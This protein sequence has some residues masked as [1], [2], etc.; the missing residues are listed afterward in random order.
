MFAHKNMS[1]KLNLPII[2]KL[3]YRFVTM[4]TLLYFV[5]QIGNYGVFYE[6]VQFF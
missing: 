4:F 1:K 3:Q 5:F 6:N 2:E